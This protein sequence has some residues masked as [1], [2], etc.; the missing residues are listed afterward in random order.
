MEK[1]EYPILEF[2]PAERAVLNPDRISK[3]L[4]IP[5]TCVICF[6]QDVLAK[7]IQTEDVKRVG[8]QK[9]E[10]GWHPIYQLQREGKSIVFFNPG[11]G[12]PL[13]AAM[14]E[15]I[16]SRGCTKFIVCGGAGVLDATIEMG[17]F[18][19]LEQA[20]RDEGTSY[21]YLPPARE[22]TADPMIVSALET[23]LQQ[24]NMVGQRVKTWTTDAIYRE[25]PARVSRRRAEGCLTVEMEAA[26]LF[27]VAH[28]RGV[29][30]GQ[31]VYA[32]D[33]LDG[34]KWQSRGWSS[35]TSIRQQLFWL[36]AACALALS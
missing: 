12:A 23:T 16:I 19:I 35:A 28:F 17:R 6:F 7:V 22:T 2:D 9:S 5:E 11:V 8:R 30:L 34:A 20:V 32:G 31:I 14:L 18:L 25:T 33:A 21:H 15:E 1:K 4:E 13:A 24:N 29:K 27:A 36:S 10:M 3:R 26:A